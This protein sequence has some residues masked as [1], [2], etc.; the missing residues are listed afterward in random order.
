MGNI[1]KIKHT[2]WRQVAEYMMTGVLKN[3]LDKLM[4]IVKQLLLVTFLE[5]HGK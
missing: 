2:I 3:G 4:R 1:S 5:A